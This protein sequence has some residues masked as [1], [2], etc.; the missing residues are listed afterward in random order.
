MPIQLI[1]PTILPPPQ[2]KKKWKQFDKETFETSW[3]FSIIFPDC[4]GNLVQ[5]Y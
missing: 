4:L 1:E 2:K 3:Y 5:K